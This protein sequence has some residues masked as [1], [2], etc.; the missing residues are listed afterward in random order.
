MGAKSSCRERESNIQVKLTLWLGN[1]RFSKRVLKRFIKW[2]FLY[3]P[4]VSVESVK[5]LRF[6]DVVGEKLTQIRRSGD[7]LVTMFFLC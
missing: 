1:F 7:D 6:W 3:V 5:L 2:L 4:E